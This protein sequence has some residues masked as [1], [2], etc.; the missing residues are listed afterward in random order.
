MSHPIA[1][2]S[3]GPRL[4]PLL[5]ALL[6]PLLG[7]P[8]TAFAQASI[9]VAKTVYLGT[10]GGASCPGS[11]LARGDIGL[12]ITF[13]F[14]IQNTGAE[15]LS[16]VTVDD[17][18]LGYNEAI[19]A[20]A[21]GQIVT[22]F[23][24]STIG[25]DATN[26]VTV[27][28]SAQSGPVQDTDTARVDALAACPS[29]CYLASDV[30]NNGG[31]D[32]LYVVDVSDA[33]SSFVGSIIPNPPVGLDANCIEA[34]TFGAPEFGV[35]FPLLYSIDAGPNCGNGP[36]GSTNLANQGFLGIIDYPNAT[37]DVVEWIPFPNPVGVGRGVFGLIPINDVDAMTFDFS[38]AGNGVLYA[39]VRQDNDPIRP[40]DEND[41][42]VQV[43]HLTGQL[44]PDA[45][46]VGIDY[47]PFEIVTNDLGEVL[48]DIDG[49]AFDPL[50]GQLWAIANASG[51]R[52][53]LVAFD[54]FT[55]R[56][57]INNGIPQR[58]PL[59]GTDG[60]T[61]FTDM[62]GLTFGVDGVLYGTSGADSET[63]ELRNSL[64][65]IERAG[66]NPGQTVRV[67]AGAI[68]GTGDYEGSD[69]FFILP[70]AFNTAA[71]VVFWDVNENGVR[72]GSETGVPNTEIF[73]WAD[74]DAD[75]IL[76]PN[77]DFPIQQAIT[78]A[79]GRYLFITPIN[80]SFFITVDR[81]GLPVDFCSFTTPTQAN[82]FV[83]Q[84][85]GV[86]EIAPDFGITNCR[87]IGD[88]VWDDLNQNG[89]QDGGESGIAGVEVVL[90]DALGMPV[91]TTTTSFAGAYLFT[92][93][94]SADYSVGFTLPA[95]YVFSAANAGA[96]NA[97]DS[98]ADPLTGL[99]GPIFTSFPPLPGETVTRVLD[100][101]AGA[102]LPTDLAITK[103]AGALVPS[104]DDP[105]FD[106]VL[107]VSNL[108]LRDA[109]N[110]LITDVLPAGL[111]YVADTAGGTYDALTRQWSATLPS[112]ATGAVSTVS[113]SVVVTNLAA[114]VI[115]N[116]AC[117]ELNPNPTGIPDGDLSNNCSEHRQAA[118]GDFVWNDRNANGVQEAGEL[119][120]A[121]VTVNLL[122][123]V[124]TVVASTVSGPGGVYAFAG[125]TPGTYQVEA[126]TA[127]STRRSPS[128]VGGDPAL[129]SDGS[130]LNGRT[131]PF[132]VAAGESNTTIDFG[133]YRP[134]TL[135]NTV[136]NDINR[137]GF[138]DAG[139]P[140]LAG[141]TVQLFDASQTPGVDLPLSSVVTDVDGNYLVTG[142]DPGQYRLYLPNPPVG[143]APST[144]PTVDSD[145]GADNDDNGN[146]PGGF[147]TPVLSPLLTLLNGDEPVSEDGDADT[148]LTVDFGFFAPFLEVTVT[149]VCVNDTPY[150]DY[151]VQVTGAPTNSGVTISFL[152]TSNTQLVSSVAGLPLSGRILYP[153]AAV[154]ANGN[155]TDWPGWFFDGTNWIQEDDGLRP[156]VLMNFNVNPELTVE[157]NYPPATPFCNA[158]P[159]VSLGNRVF[160]D[161]NG[162]GSLDVGESG[163]DGVTLE[164]WSVGVD[165]VIGGGD[166]ALVDIDPF[167]AGL[168][169]TVTSGS[170]G[171]YLFNRVIS[172]TYYVVIP[173]SQFQAG[174]P[175]AG[176]I[177]SPGFGFDSTTDE[178]QDENGQD[179]LQP[180]V[181]GVSSIA[182]IVAAA[183]APVDDL[184]LGPLSGQADASEN[185]TLDFG[186][187]VPPVIGDFVW[188]DLNRNGVQDAGEPGVDGV[189]VE[190]LDIDFQTLAST[191]TSGGGSYSFVT[192]PGD[193][194]VRFSP[195]PG[196]ELVPPF[197]GGDPAT[198][199][200]AD[201]A[202]FTTSQFTV[203][204]GQVEN[205]IDAGLRS[206]LPGL[207]LEK[208]VA[209]GADQ[210]CPGSE[211]VVVLSGQD[212]TY[213]FE[214][215]NTG[216]TFVA[217]TVLTDADITPQLVQNIGLLAP[218]QSVTVA[219]NRV[220]GADLVNVGQVDGD[221]AHTN[222][223]PLVGFPPLVVT[224]TATVD[225]IGPSIDLRKSIYAGDL[226]V[227]GCEGLDFIAV[228]NGQIV[229]YC[230]VVTN[231]GDSRLD[232]VVIDDANLTPPVS[233]SIGTLQAGQS[234][235]QAVAV[236]A[237]ADLVNT[238]TATGQPPAGPPVRDDDPATVDVVNPGIDIQKTVYLGHNGGAGC[239][240]VEIVSG[241]NNTAVTY[242]FLISNTGD[243]L[244]T[245]VTVTDNDVTPPFSA[246]LGSLPV[247]G[248]VTAFVE[249]VISADLVNVATG[250][251]VPPAGP[252]VT[253]S[254]PA[255]VQFIPV[256]SIGDFVWDDLN[257]NGIQDAG[258]P[259][260][261]GVTVRLLNGTNL[262]VLAATST[263]GTGGYVFNNLVPGQYAVEFVAPANG[264]F[265][266]AGQGGNPALDSDPDA[267]GR[268]VVF[269]FAGTSPDTTRDAGLYFPATI[270]GQVRDDR[271]GDGD[272]TDPDDPLPG[273]T[274][275]LFRDPTCTGVEAGA[276]IS[277]VV[278]DV[279]G[280][281][282]FAGLVPGC[283]VVR[284]VNPAGWTSTGD[285]TSPNDDRV[286]VVVT[287]GQTSGG[288]DFLD[289]LPGIL[290]NL[291]WDDLDGN[292]LQDQGEPGI[293]GVT[294]FLI[295]ALGNTVQTDI[296]DVNGLYGF[297]G[298]L[299]GTYTIGFDPSTL[300]P[301]YVQTV[302]VPG[303]PTRNSDPDPVTR[304]TPPFL[305]E[306]RTVNQD[307]DLG[308]YGPITLGDFVWRDANNNGVQDVGETG[309]PGVTVTLFDALTS[310]PVGSPTVTDASGRYQFSGLPPGSYFVQFDLSTLPP[311][312]T[313]STPD[314]GG[315]DAVDSDADPVTGLTPPTPFLI[316][317]TTHNTLDLG[318]VPLGVI[319]DT[320]WFDLNGNGL[321]DENLGPYLEAGQ[322]RPGQGLNNVT[323]ELYSLVGGVESLIT[324]TVTASNA[325]Q[326]GFYQFT[327]LVPATYRV[328]VV[329]STVPAFL[330]LNTTPLFYDID[331]VNN[332]SVENADFGFNNPPTAVELVSFTA[333]QEAG[334]VRLEW[335]TGSETDNLGFFL[336][337]SA[338]LNGERVK[339]NATL[340]EGQ[341][342]GAGAVYSYVDSSVGAGIW[343]YWLED[344]EFDGDT[345]IHGPARVAV[346]PLEGLTFALGEAGVHRLSAGVLGPV[347]DVQVDGVAVPALLGEG[348]D[349]YFYAP[350]GAEEAKVVRS[351]A[352]LRM[353]AQP[354][355]PAGGETV[356]VVSE[357]GRQAALAS[358]EDADSYLVIGFAG[359]DLLVFDITDPGAPQVLSEVAVI[360]IPGDHGAYFSLT[361][362]EPARVIVIRRSDVPSLR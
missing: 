1:R 46:G 282:A 226:G 200:N 208:T 83:P 86:N 108:G 341:G 135:G 82:F 120:I 34:I 17:P 192:V 199:S 350:A 152:L 156:S 245:D 260:L 336:Y 249:R 172:G 29:F 338:R 75:G 159:V 279:N 302:F 89:V 52:D 21:P 308:A 47:I 133:L 182:L 84:F 303:E 10:D 352:P 160:A 8:A 167:T 24:E 231:T 348:G 269:A 93:L 357:D 289:V 259:G 221:P 333:T 79:D 71:G 140:G 194:F 74:A 155:P 323:V 202:D 197:Q 76:D 315:D 247:G 243:A 301:G 337:R 25:G 35:P 99:T 113:L 177:S 100:V 239:P 229:T 286:P 175:L 233:L 234:V 145:N 265:S 343:Y 66:A 340:V 178:D 253:N 300:P 317:N 31:P 242:C 257:A 334:V 240:G 206:L 19:G 186:F 201:P 137:D 171:F 81:T 305:V 274:V 203:V 32:R 64:F 26:V 59:L 124:G 85:C 298:V 294:L 55:G 213:C 16:A 204:A 18:T 193:Y 136:W 28:A 13:C 251:G 313:V 118:I 105:R 353:P 328:R 345:T 276:A 283:Y 254:D 30:G 143:F 325:T 40:G 224:N 209:V 268:T 176:L 258:E 278:T 20:L 126:I 39:A 222:G 2:K 275:Q 351:D 150:L 62:E 261:S 162:N 127:G 119:G 61:R 223:V 218:G 228:T 266:T 174:G 326:N 107:Q 184:E 169:S 190:L 51:T 3:S 165:G 321:P 146:Q 212:L 9:Q 296:T 332:A 41:L 58:F 331:L 290:G 262:T 90:F 57:L 104:A 346:K 295:D 151:S 7:L 168:Q 216:Q 241:T 101:D 179:S 97:V 163:L 68:P 12:P 318:G 109:S 361:G 256:S 293:P 342:T 67:G 144:E 5:T 306:S 43:D 335:V 246:V 358:L 78:D 238:A 164:L 220:S 309:I 324:S 236:A 117:V 44:I 80:E 232:D 125:V 142:I 272:L 205:T 244:L 98:D 22:R 102:F 73:L 359:D 217:N 106:Y 14:S 110:I 42:L 154:D 166:D 60:V 149:P 227:A 36:I 322:P 157:V 237:T 181:N 362:E 130:P 183:N 356:V 273:V 23:F 27:T 147:G 311:D 65:I 355:A 158:D 88:F 141:V 170:G 225:V 307:Q 180:A 207:M 195:P 48:G 173:A 284:E 219:V 198:D 188:Q 339:V 280:N 38:F 15:A 50:S 329:R 161:V 114:G 185:L 148:D 267:S 33:S 287:S 211:V 210:P 327:G 111:D 72:D 292:G 91:A 139:E 116:T 121:G 297:G 314:Q 250:S 263:S 4:R 299:P 255:I 288:N 69:C 54:K 191:N 132:S 6:L 252:P 95:G 153:G 344:V 37:N 215:T 360:T 349:L 87:E 103:I 264:V 235:T 45:F 122:D 56:V 230:F 196:T 96:D 316:S 123:G 277:N 70:E 115:I 347:A 129:D 319:G 94:P 270:T 330:S 138:R 77:I 291:V 354:A 92:N 285:R 134:M 187:I 320:V 11:E 53:E 112:L 189:L 304:R 128:G 49:M 271:D 310:A 63:L 248:V 214:I 281:Y 312:T 131:A